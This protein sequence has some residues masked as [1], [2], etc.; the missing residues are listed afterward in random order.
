[1]LIVA[2]ISTVAL[3]IWMGFFMMSSLPLL[4]LKHDTA[5]DARFIRGLFNIYYVGLMSVATAGALIHAISGRYGI[6]LGVG[7]MAM[8]GFAGHRW[9]VGR[10]D[11]LRSTMTC[12]RCGWHP[13]VPPAPHNGHG[14]QCAFARRV[15]RGDDAR[16]VWTLVSDRVRSRGEAFDAP[17][18]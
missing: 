2:L 11:T 4:I 10:M 12:R 14:A 7:C 8:I 16:V 6:A 5:L 3:L 1:M 13:A 9:L 18:E 15:L 17:T